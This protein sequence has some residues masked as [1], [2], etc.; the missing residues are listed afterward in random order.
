LPEPIEREPRA[1]AVM[2]ETLAVQAAALHC[3][4]MR[5]FAD[6]LSNKE[7]SLR[8][9]SR[10]LKAQAQCRTALRLLIKLR[11]AEQSQKKTRNRTN[12]L[13]KTKIALYDQQLTKTSAGGD[14]W[15]RQPAPLKLDIG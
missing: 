9:V 3:L 1:A 15:F 6:V 12:E 2:A 10:A 13:M 11:A 14:L 5:T 4:F 7:R 8:N